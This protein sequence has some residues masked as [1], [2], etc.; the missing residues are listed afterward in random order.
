MLT[1]LVG[2]LSAVDLSILTVVVTAVIAAIRKIWPSLRRLNHFVDDWFGEDS[3]DGV[4]GRPG[5]MRRLASLDERGVT[6][7]RRLNAIEHELKP[8]SGKSLRD[9]VDRIESGVSN[10]GP[11]KP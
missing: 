1:P 3:R 7:D 10:D 9:A 11:V 5:V 6:T 2:P 8:N 4:E